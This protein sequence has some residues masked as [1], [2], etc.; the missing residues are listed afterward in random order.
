M[1]GEKKEKR[2]QERSFSKRKKNPNFPAKFTI[3]ENYKNF[4]YFLAK[5]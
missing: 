1:S 5:N 3:E 4:Q 2:D